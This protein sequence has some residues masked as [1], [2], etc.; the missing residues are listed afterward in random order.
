MVL[1][2]S[3]YHAACLENTATHPTTSYPK[4]T[5]RLSCYRKRQIQRPWHRWKYENEPYKKYVVKLPLK[6][7]AFMRKETFHSITHSTENSISLKKKLT[8]SQLVKKFPAFYGKLKFIIRLT[9]VRIH[10]A[11]RSSPRHPSQSY[12]L[13]IHFNIILPSTPTS[14]K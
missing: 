13:K 7:K 5:V 2:V 1:Y 8:V 9:Y 12:F 3:G 6:S 4:P 14:S 10:K 11:E